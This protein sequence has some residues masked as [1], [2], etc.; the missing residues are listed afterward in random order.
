MYSYLHYRFCRE[1]LWT[2]A[3]LYHGRIYLVVIK[4]LVAF[5]GDT[6]NFLFFCRNTACSWSYISTTGRIND[7]LY[8][9]SIYVI[10]PYTGAISSSP[11]RWYHI[12]SLSRTLWGKCSPLIIVYSLTICNIKLC[13]MLIK[14]SLSVLFI[15]A[16]FNSPLL[17]QR[18]Y[19]T[20][21]SSFS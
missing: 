21:Q 17:D 8:I 2:F 10:T 19:I 9:L 1:I 6:Y 4:Y 14:I 3:G 20:L 16:N 12:S 13:P 18:L 11:C 15:I 5:C 7:A